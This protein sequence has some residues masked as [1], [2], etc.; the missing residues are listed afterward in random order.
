LCR[1]NI[2]AITS[3]I[4]DRALDVQRLAVRIEQLARQRTSHRRGLAPLAVAHR[5]TEQLGLPR[6]PLA[7]IITATV[8]PQFPRNPPE[9]TLQIFTRR[10]GAVR[11]RKPS[12][13][14]EPRT[15][16]LTQS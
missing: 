8:L 7:P 4:L 12:A 5:M 10:K 6:S 11:L 3:L 1:G 2:I 16:K 14:S 13:Y 15:K 9:S